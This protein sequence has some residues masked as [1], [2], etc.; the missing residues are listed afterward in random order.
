MCRSSWSKPI[1]VLGERRV[2]SP[3]QNLHHRLLDKA[4][5]HGRDAKLSHPPPS[6]LGISTRR[7]WFRFCTGPV[8]QL[9]PNSQPVLLQVRAELTNGHPVDART[10][11]VALHLPQRFLQ[12]CSLTYFLHRFGW[13]WLGVQGSFATESDFVFP[14][15]CRFHPSAPMRS[16]ANWNFSR[17]SLSRF[18]FLLASP[19]VRAF[20]PRSRLGLSV[21]SPFGDGVL[22][23]LADDMTYYAFC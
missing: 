21:D 13:C 18:L 6:G 8:Q 2:P 3:L 9:L 19:L 1:A 22:T 10:T 23:S 14:P 4:V 15:A 17:L 12:V 16:P 5:Q 11:L 7:H 20:S